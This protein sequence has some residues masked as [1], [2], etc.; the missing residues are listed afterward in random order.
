[1]DVQLPDTGC[2]ILISSTSFYNY[3]SDRRTRKRYYIYDGTAYLESS[4]TS[5]YPYDYSGTCLTTGD[6]VYR[7]ELQVYFPFLS[8]I[9][10]VFV[11]F[12]LYRVIIKRLMP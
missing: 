3:S 9:L 4:S 12:V 5:Q 11:L 7:P 8:S 6:L 10:L 1:M 2:N